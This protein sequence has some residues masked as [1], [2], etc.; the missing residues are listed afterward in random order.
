MRVKSDFREIRAESADTECPGRIIDSGCQL[1]AALGTT[2][3]HDGAT[4]TG[5]HAK[6]EAVDAR[7][8]TV[9]RLEST[10]PLSHWELLVLGLLDVGTAGGLRP[11]MD[12]PE[13]ARDERVEAVHVQATFREYWPP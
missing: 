7:A 3:V 6:T 9:V 4:G 2:S 10:L 5:P 8:T 13:P 1:G 11:L 12:R